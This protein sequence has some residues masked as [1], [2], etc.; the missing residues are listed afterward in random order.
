[1]KS[2]K[3]AVALLS[4]GIAVG[5]FAQTDAEKRKAI[6]DRIDADKSGGVTQ[7][8]L[9]QSGPDELKMIKENFDAMD[10]NKDGEV[11]IEERDAFAASKGKQ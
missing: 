8:E 3:L 9:K 5:A 10:T 7:E 6:F 11:T 1:M 4:A 2:L